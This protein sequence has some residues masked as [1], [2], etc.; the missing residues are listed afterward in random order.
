[1]AHIRFSPMPTEIVRAYQAGALDAYGRKPEQRLSDGSGLPCRH[2]LSDIEAGEGYLVLAHR[3]F[4][5]LQPYAETGPIFLHARPCDRHAE[6][7]STPAMFL[8][9]RQMIVRGYDRSERIVYGTG[10]VVPAGEIA[11][12]AAALLDRADIAFVDLRSSSNNCFQCR[13]ERA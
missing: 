10:A 3:P 11:A 8:V 4:L 1:M 2:C 5:A 7:A 12:A 9:R 13:I 6:T